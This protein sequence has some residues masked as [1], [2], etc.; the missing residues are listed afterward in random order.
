MWL[1][2][3]KISAVDIDLGIIL[4]F[5]RGVIGI[6]TFDSGIKI[7]IPHALTLLMERLQ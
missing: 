5:I 1:S 2:S 7:N 4:A 3:L 6:I